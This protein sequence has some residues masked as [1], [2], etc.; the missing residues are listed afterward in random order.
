MQVKVSDDLV[1]YN[2]FKNVPRL[3]VEAWLKANVGK[4]GYYSSKHGWKGKWIC[5]GMGQYTVFKFLNT[6][7]ALLFKLTWGG[8]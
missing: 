1:I 6:K 8:Q 3:D 4:E 7:D 5:V 2:G